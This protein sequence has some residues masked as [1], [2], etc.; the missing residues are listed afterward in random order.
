[1][2]SGDESLSTRLLASLKFWTIVGVLCAVVGTVAFFLGRDYVGA[3][4]HR[5]EVTQRVPDIQP[6]GGVETVPAHETSLD[7]PP[8]KPIITI[9]EREPTAREQRRALRELTEPRETP[10]RR[11]DRTGRT[12]EPGEDNGAE[13]EEGASD[14]SAPAPRGRFVVSAGAFADHV[15]AE[16]QAQRLAE[17]GY[18]PF[19]TTIDRDG[20]TYNRVNV[21]A[22]DSRDQADELTEKLKSQGFDAAVG[23][24]QG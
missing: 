9:S 13:D 10:V 4:L 6:R 16:R 23:A 8:V 7:N 24:G 11:A 17:Q 19:I 20:V 22:F 14:E 15:N 21:G 3:H 2:A 1:M 5:M 18:E 12:D